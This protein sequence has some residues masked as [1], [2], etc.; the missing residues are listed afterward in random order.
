MV[1]W[2]YLQHI[3]G[4]K[5]Q[6]YHALK[7]ESFVSD[8]GSWA[9]H[10]LFLIK[11]IWIWIREPWYQYL[12]INPSVLAK[13]LYLVYGHIGYTFWN[14]I[15]SYWIYTKCRVCYAGIKYNKIRNKVWYNHDK[16][17]LGPHCFQSTGTFVICFDLLNNHAPHSWGILRPVRGG[18]TCS[19]H[20]WPVFVTEHRLELTH[21][22]SCHHSYFCPTCHWFVLSLFTDD[23]QVVENITDTGYPGGWALFT[24]D[25]KMLPAKWNCPGKREVCSIN[26]SLSY[27]SESNHGTST[28]LALL[29]LLQS[30]MPLLR[31]DIEWKR[32]NAS[33]EERSSLYQM[34]FRTGQNLLPDF[35]W[36]LLPRADWTFLPKSIKH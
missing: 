30:V 5:T 15:K 19:A 11:D 28:A 14:L 1:Q 31:L 29:T 16:L 18:I 4:C 3:W 2:S 17:L 21:I 32:K 9:G 33:P 27:G 36:S 7:P 23:H 8:W 20:W 6:I 26:R 34:H 25:M 12:M 22:R 10:F 35:V 13:Q 24:V